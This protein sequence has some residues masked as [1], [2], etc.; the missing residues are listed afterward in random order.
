M[1]PPAIEIRRIARPTAIDAPDAGDFVA[2]AEIMARVEEETYG[3]AGRAPLLAGCSP[4]DP[5]PSRRLSGA[6]ATN[7]ARPSLACG[8]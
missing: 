3:T 8:R 5:E 1:T 2:H 7:P 4:A 6:G